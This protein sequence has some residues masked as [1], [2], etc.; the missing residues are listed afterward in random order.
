MM[1]IM[2][3]VKWTGATNYLFFCVCLQ[4]ERDLLSPYV[5][6]RDTPF[7]HIL[8]GS[9]SCTIQDVLTQLAAIK[10]E[11]LNADLD[12]LRNQFALTTWTIQSCANALA[13]NVWDMD[14]E[15]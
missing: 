11:S 2:I 14:N 7:R 3:K 13:G 4:V 9:G 15:L 12:L 8:L 10:E 5:S 6:P 1:M